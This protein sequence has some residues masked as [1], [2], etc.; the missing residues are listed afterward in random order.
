MFAGEDQVARPRSRAGHSGRLQTGG[1]GRL[2]SMHRTDRNECCRVSWLQ[3]D[4]GAMTET[5]RIGILPALERTAG[6]CSASL[7]VD[8]SAGRGF[9][10]TAW[11]TRAAMVSEPLGGRRHAQPGRERRGRPD[12]R[13]T[14]VRPRLRTPARPRDG[15]ST[16]S[17][18]V[19]PVYH[20]GSAA[21]CGPAPAPRCG[22]E[23]KR[24]HLDAQAAAPGQAKWVSALVLSRNRSVVDRTIP[25]WFSCSSVSVMPAPGWSLTS[26]R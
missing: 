26:S 6:F 13:R 1:R 14:R 2:P 20:A 24:L 21:I 17:L 9:A 15:L 10:T 16:V 7:M 18:S 25:R 11:E 12:R 3:G 19:E 5:F 8:R 4:H 23:W 22:V